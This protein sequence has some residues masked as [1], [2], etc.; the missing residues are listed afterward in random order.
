MSTYP[1]PN[2]ALAKKLTPIAWIVSAVVLALVVAMRSIKINLGVDFSFLPALYSV[3]N[4]LVAV[5]LIGA[6][7]FI[8]RKK[9][10]MHRR[11]IFVAMAGST[12]FLLMYVLYHITSEPVLYCGTGTMRLVYFFF[13]ISHVALAA[14][15]FPFIL[16]TFIRGYTWQVAAH[17]RMSKWVFWVWLYVALTGPLCYL[18]LAPCK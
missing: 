15:S 12:L 2:N 9:V 7:Y 1:Q 14:V 11:A 18:M 17:K 3:L 10:M 4:S 16:F 8:S 5:A 6:L 13:L